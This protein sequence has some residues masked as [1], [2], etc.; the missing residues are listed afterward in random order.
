MGGCH[1]KR[2]TVDMCDREVVKQI[3]TV[4]LTGIRYE[5]TV[6][7]VPKVNQC[8]VVKVYDGDTITVA[9]TVGDD[10]TI[11]RFN[12]R[13]AGI[14]CPE[15]QPT[16]KNTVAGREEKEIALKA[17]DYMSELLLGKIVKV[18]N[19]GSEKY[20]RLLATVKYNGD[21]INDLMLQKRFAIQY[22]GIVPR[23]WKRYHETGSLE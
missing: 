12:V 4:D 22:N 7:F 6:E 15:M 3:G 23:S 13:F 21:N 5:D 9:T 1:S 10:P 2:H 14:D 17:R 16:F 18:V 19:I 11:Y 8:V 20:G